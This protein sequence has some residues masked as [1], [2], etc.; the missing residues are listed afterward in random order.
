M[1][2]DKK[3]KEL[4]KVLGRIKSVERQITTLK[5][6]LTVPAVTNPTSIA[7]Q[8]GEV[9]DRLP[10]NLQQIQDLERELENLYSLKDRDYEEIKA[11]TYDACTEHE[12]WVLRSYY[13]FH[14]DRRTTAEQVFH[15]RGDF[16]LRRRHYERRVTELH[17]DGMKRLREWNTPPMRLGI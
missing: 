2:Y 8:G 16:L 1:N 9:A 10:L 17:R 15:E 7:V 3:L 4:S 13:F 14:M 6:G 11:V 12:T 5:E